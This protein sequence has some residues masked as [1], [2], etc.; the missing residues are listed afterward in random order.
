MC[1]AGGVT[2]SYF[3]WVQDIQQLM[4]SEKQVNEKLQELMDFSGDGGPKITISP[5][6]IAAD[7]HVPL[8]NLQ[9]GIF[10]LSNMSIDAGFNL[11]FTGKPARFRF[12]FASREDKFHLQVSFLA[13]GGFFGIA[14][15]TDG[16]EMVEAAF[17]FGAMLALDI[18]VA[19]GEVHIMAGIYFSYAKNEAA[20][21]TC[22]LTGYVRL[23]GSMS[24]L[25]LISLSIEF[26]MGLTYENNG[27]KKKVYG[28]A[29]LTIEIEILFITIPVEMHVH[30]Q[31][32]DSPGDPT[33]AEQF[34]LVAGN[35]TYWTDYCDAFAA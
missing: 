16:V 34:P 33:F 24:I 15:G 6:G 20:V 18:G 27:G 35:P 28:D 10:G 13:G 17:E 25:G 32:G 2:V 4:W 19:S 30:R 14:I 11:P 29:T 31:F 22:I 5:T 9:I 12:G 7:M 23:G 1:N 8:P 3:E 21:E 26:Y